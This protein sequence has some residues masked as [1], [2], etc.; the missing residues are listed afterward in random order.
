MNINWKKVN[1]KTHYWGAVI[2]AIPV[3]IVIGTGVLLLLKKEIEW[4]QPPTIKGI[5]KAPEISFEQVLSVVRQVPGVGIKNWSDIDRLDVRPN[6]GVIKV[7]GN[8]QWEIQLDQKTMKVLHVAY[9]R[10]DFIESIHD[11]TYFHD[12]AKLGVFLPSA[13]ILLVLWVTGM[14]LFFT[15]LF[16]KQ[17][18]KAKKKTQ[19]DTV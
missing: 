8:N 14:Y 10:S 16:A 13:I 19:R 17:R 7:R 1:R 5:S 18:V 15:T 6:K 12:M 2:C 4:V 3:L 11:G 9:R